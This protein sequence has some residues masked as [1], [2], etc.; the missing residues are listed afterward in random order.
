[1]TATD[2]TGRIPASAA[3]SGHTRAER[4]GTIRKV[5]PWLF[6]TSMVMVFTIAAKVFNGT[7]FLNPSGIQSILVYATQILLLA[8]GETL[9]IIAAGIDLSVGFQLGLAGVVAAQIMQPLYA[10]DVA[11]A[12][13]IGLGMLG[14]IL[15]CVIP[16]WLNGVLVAR[17]KVPPFIAT[18]GVG[19]VAFGAALL[20]SGGYPVAKQPAYL[21]Q[22]G[23]GYLFYIWP[24]HGVSFFTRPP[25]ATPADLPSITPLVPNV[26]IITIIVALICWFVLSKTQFGQHIFAIGGNFEASMRAGIPVQR[27]L[28]KV[29]VIAG[30]LCGVAGVLWASRFS[31]GAA[32]AG[33]VTLLM[34]IA[35]VVIGGASLFGGEGGIVGT[36]VGALTIATIQ[37]GLVVLGMKPFWQYIVIGIVV[38]VAVIIDQFGR[39]LG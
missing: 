3:Q 35:A 16:G 30:L 25:T 19:W 6:L 22:L 2:E 11:P 5:W 7:N 20:I 37:F 39:A 36:I 24:G 32:N 28:I 23:N 17:V 34:S 33:E 14:G 29:Y 8:L 15:V 12:V 1:M 38:I 9:I 26:V 31:S 21:G 10:H 18:L 13:T 27:T 4:L